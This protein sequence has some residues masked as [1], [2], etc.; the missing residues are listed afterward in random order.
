MSHQSS[1]KLATK[2]SECGANFAPYRKRPRGLEGLAV[3][4][5]PDGKVIRVWI[6][7]GLDP[8]I[9]T[10]K[11]HRQATLSLYED[12]REVISQSPITLGKE[13]VTSTY[14]R[15]ASS[16]IGVAL[17]R[18]PQIGSSRAARRE[19]ILEDGWD[20]KVRKFLRQVKAVHNSDPGSKVTVPPN[21]I[22]I[23]AEVHTYLPAQRNNLLMGIDE[24][25]HFVCLLPEKANSVEEAHEILRSD[26]ARVKGTLR[27]GEFFFV[28][29]TEGE[30]KWVEEAQ[31]KNPLPYR[32]LEVG[33]SHRAALT[34]L[35]RGQTVE[36]FVIG[37]VTDQRWGRHEH[38]VLPEWRKV[39]R[40]T[41]IR[42]GRRT[43]TRRRTRYYD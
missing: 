39:V 13:E 30:K 9:S 41:E 37:L 24:T 23:R 31:Y 21:Y 26:E 42:T 28:P 35:R 40:N 7:E 5:S 43:S 11:K 16:L 29:L 33:S 22:T 36:R 8:E 4:G 2:L 27:Q 18:A 20:K 38:L 15:T 34:L 19:A 14:Q 32:Q 3:G 6:D 10:S 25:S 1:K 17:K 12:K